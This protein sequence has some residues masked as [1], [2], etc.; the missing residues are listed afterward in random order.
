MGSDRIELDKVKGEIEMLV[1]RRADDPALTSGAQAIR[2]QFPDLEVSIRP[3]QWLEMA[4]TP[5]HL[6]AVAQV[7][8]DQLGYTYLLSLTGVDWQE[9]GLQVVYHLQNLDKG[10]FLVL[11]VTLPAQDPHV[12]SVTHLWPTANWQEREAWDL[13]GIYFDGH[14]DLRRILMKEG[15]PGHPLRKDY[16]DTRPRRERLPK[17]ER[18]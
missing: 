12:P 3:D 1:A 10:L 7:L 16:R 13:V 9:K 8:R 17:I 15:W 2:E 6:L 11:T 14:P 5:D 4:V 18:R